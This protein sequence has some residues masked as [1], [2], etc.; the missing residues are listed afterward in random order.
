MT[1]RI[2][3]KNLEAVAERIN[4]L[5]HAPITSYRKEGDK[6]RAN[7]GNYHIDYQNNGVS[8]HRMQCESGSTS[9]ALS[10]GHTTKRELY[11]C[12]FA[13]IAGICAGRESA[14]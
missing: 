7:I 5:L 3:D 6:Y 13:F 8:L 4:R 14:Q 10:V 12:M 2:T 1:Q 9:D 11:N